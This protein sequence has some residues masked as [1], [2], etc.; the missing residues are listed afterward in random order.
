MI[1]LSDLNEI[2]SKNIYRTKCKY[3]ICDPK[4]LCVF[5]LI[6]YRHGQ[7]YLCLLNDKH[8]SSY[9]KK[10]NDKLDLYLEFDFKLNIP[11][12]KLDCDFIIL[13]TTNDIETNLFKAIKNSSSNSYTFILSD[14]VLKNINI[15]NTTSLMDVGM[16]DL[17][18]GGNNE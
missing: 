5:V 12:F 8:N 6:L 11:C 4:N 18:E 9:I 1:D 16:Y 17:P 2:F 7:Y 13:D 10:I 3:I 15:E 14:F